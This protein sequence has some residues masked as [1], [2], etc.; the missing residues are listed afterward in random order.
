MAADTGRRA[1]V[2][3]R[4][5][6]PG[7]PAAATPETRTL[8]VDREEAGRVRTLADLAEYVA[9]DGAP[10]WVTEKMRQFAAQGEAAIPGFQALLTDPA[11]EVA[12]LGAEGLAT[13]GTPAALQELVQYLQALPPEDEQR[14]ELASTLAETA[15]NAESVPY[16]NALLAQAELAEDVRDA[17]ISALAHSLT[18]TDLKEL[19]NRYT[20]TQD[21][22]MRQNWADVVRQV[23]GAEHVPQLIALAGEPGAAVASDPLV[24][25]A[26]DTLAVIGAPQG[27]AKLLAWADQ[28][29]D[30][31]T[32][33][34]L[35][36]A[37]GRVDNP[38]SLAILQ[39][40]AAS[41]S[42]RQQTAAENA[43]K[44]FAD[45]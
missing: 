29:P 38:A 23:E 43:L 25:A 1:T 10:E 5:N 27:V 39:R 2:A 30:N 14:R 9:N 37:I 33:A 42:A 44:N 26:W 17:A 6:R 4:S 8:D 40:A 22:T 15:R 12:R 41:G 11:P 18:A 20:A 34:A 36:H 7:M 31:A 19:G 28:A 13:I 16:W 24:L 32:A 35:A 3:R 45:R 21:E